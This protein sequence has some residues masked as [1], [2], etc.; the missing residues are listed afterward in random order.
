MTQTEPAFPEGVAASVDQL[1]GD[2]VTHVGFVARDGHGRHALLDVNDRGAVTFP[3]VARLAGEPASS[4]LARCVTERLGVVPRAVFPLPGP[5][6]HEGASTWLFAGL[7][8]SA[9]GRTPRLSGDAQRIVWCDRDE[10]YARLGHA[11][12]AGLRRR[13]ELVLA[14]ALSAALSTERRILLAV[15]TLHR[16]GFERL[17]LRVERSR[18]AQ[19]WRFT[20]GSPAAPIVHTHGHGQRFFGWSDAC[21]D[22]PDEL[23]ERLL[24]RAHATLFDAWGDDAANVAWLDDVIARTAPEGVP[25]DVGDAP[26]PHGFVSVE[27]HARV[28]TVAGPP[29][30]ASAW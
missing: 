10:A 7:S 18:Q 6:S 19:T 25:V 9:T 24:Y 21:F 1:V 16:M 17:R 12:D 11:R 8:A 20:L 28:S 2:E 14:Y 13:D 5:W 3:T 30:D 27:R 29:G 23:A 22:A 4:A 15:Q 26:A